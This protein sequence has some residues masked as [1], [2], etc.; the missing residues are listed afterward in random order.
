MSTP[1]LSAE[2]F[3]QLITSLDPVTNL[4]I[5]TGYIQAADGQGNRVWQS[6]FGAISTSSD[7][8]IFPIPDLPTALW[9]LSNATGT[10]PT[11]PAQGAFSWVTSNAILVSPAQVE[12]SASGVPAWDSRAWSVEG[13]RQGA[14][15]TFQTLQTSA[16]LGVGFTENPT[17]PTPP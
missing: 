4:P 16:E 9:D 12:K 14:F 13:Y 15:I 8:T 7:G 5:S 2:Y 6:V 11:G 1:N 17:N 10:G 3:S